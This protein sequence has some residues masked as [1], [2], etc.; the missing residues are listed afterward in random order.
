[1][2]EIIKLIILGIVQG[3][4]EFLPISSS[5]HLILLQEM[6]GI[7]ENTL[8]TTI[9]LHLGTLLAVVIYYFKDLLLLAK[10]EGRT[11]LIW[12]IVATLPACV[13]GLIFND[14]FESLTSSKVLAFTFLITTI[15]LFVTQKLAKNSVKK[16]FKTH[17]AL[18]MGL[19]QCVAITPGISRSGS[20][21]FGGVLVKNDPNYVAKFSFF[22]SIPIILGSLI[23]E[24]FKVELISI[25]WLTL[26]FGFVASFISGVVAIKLTIK[27]IGKCNFMWFGI[28][29]MALSLLCF[30]QNFVYTIW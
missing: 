2:K 11:T 10:P 7:T 26:S 1:M 25:N 30:V 12:L 14:L 18:V 15:M 3:L 13:V 28:Y 23:L 5:G 27:A 6:L 19:M 29:L 8:F 21:I 9:V 22:M 24:L 4:T 17:S 20:T 16:P